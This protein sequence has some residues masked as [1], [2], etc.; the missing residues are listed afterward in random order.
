MNGW[1]SYNWLKEYKRMGLQFEESSPFRV[2]SNLAG[3]VCVT[4]PERFIVPAKLSDENMR[5]TMKNRSRD[6][7]PALSYAIHLTK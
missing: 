4:Y 3:S 5:K 1:D 2:V 6:R 7:L